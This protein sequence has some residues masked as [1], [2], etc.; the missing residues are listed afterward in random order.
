MQLWTRVL[1]TRV[2]VDTYI[3]Y[4]RPSGHVS[5][6]TRVLNTRVNFVYIN[7]KNVIKVLYM[8]ACIKY[9]CPFGHVYLIH[10]ANCF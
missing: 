2:Q 8:D 3:I 6:W 7:K 4:T 9:T 10:V 1:N 5:I